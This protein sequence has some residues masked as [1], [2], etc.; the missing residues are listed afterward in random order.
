MNIYKK[1]ILCGYLFGLSVT[2]LY[3]QLQS[4]NLRTEY[5]T[6]PFVDASAPR[7]SWELDGSGFNRFQTAYQ[8]QV[9][10][11]LSKFERNQADLWD[12]DKV[13]SSQTN[14]IVYKGKKLLSGQEV[15]WRVRTWDEQGKVGPWSTAA[16]WEM[17]KLNN[18]DWQAQWIGYD[19]NPLAKQNTTYH[20]PPSPYL[21]TERKIEKA[22]QSARL[23]IASLGLHEF[24]VNGQKIGDDYFASGWTD[25]HKRVHYN[26]YDITQ[27]ISKGTNVFGSI[28]GPGW[29]A[30][31]LGYALLVGTKQVTQFYGKFPLLKAQIEITY[32]DGSSDTISTD[33]SWKAQIGAIQEADFLQG[34]LHDAN[35]ELIGWDLA[36]YDDK[37]WKEVQII[38]K[39]T[40]AVLSLYPSNPVRV[41]EK[42]YPKSITPSKA[43]TYMV[44]FG[45]NFAGNIQVHVKG[46]KGDTLTFRYGEM[47]YPDGRLMTE[48]LRSARATDYYVLRGDPN[49]ETW[50]PKFTFHGFQ[51]VE[52]SGLKF[53]PKKDFIEGLVLSSNLQNVG[54]FQ[55]DNAMLNQ[56]YSNI[57]WTQRANYL[58][59][60]TDCPQRDERLGW[61]G[62]AQVYMRSAAFIADIAPFHT[63]WIQDLHDSQWPNGAYP[64]YAP[65]PVNAKGDAAI[66]SSDTFSPGWSEA[67]IIC[68]Y[69]IYRTYNDTR[70]VELSMPYM[71]RFMDFLQSRTQQGIFK[72]GSFEDISPKGGF[73]DWLSVGKK[74]SPDLL[75]SMY[76]YYCAKLM[77]EMSQAIDRDDLQVKYTADMHSIKD[78]FKKHFMSK[79]KKLKADAEHYGNGDGYVDGQLGFTGHTQTSYA[80]ALYFG[81]L[82]EEDAVAAGNYLRQLIIDNDNKLTTGFL[83]FKPL[84]PTLSQSGSS[85]KA[86]ALLLSTEYPSL[87]YEVINGATSIWERWDSYIQGE[88]FRHNAAMNSFSH[89]AFGAVNEWMFENMIGIKALSPGYNTIIIRPEIEP[90]TIGAVDGSYHS[91][92]GL[93][94]SSWKLN[95]Q[96]VTQNFS[97]PIN[98]NATICIPDGATDI[99]LNNDSLERH[100]LVKKQEVVGN[101]SRLIVGSGNYSLTYT[102]K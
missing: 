82:D 88:G 3:A 84:L 83:G 72:E 39:P 44:D 95:N 25:Y 8:I 65:M 48:N 102:K 42:L 4:T 43:N 34:E 64:V 49:G 12:T 63:K 5:K 9:S 30:G 22:V 85:D 21:R 58:D 73:A 13:L 77:A 74:T 29:Y 81:I 66:R 90:N 18:V 57:V 2:F 87:G 78:A 51:Y 11:D 61:T 76:Y 60:P 35:K 93:I 68:T 19:T 79:D 56:L 46:A 28:L 62:D 86:Y 1:I 98:V 80:N 69:E 26:V 52:V 38:E 17:G 67:G 31:Y 45:Q 41:I 101:E 14:Q 47:C 37:G 59:V 10:S 40:N 54:K 71:I 24:Y 50:T 20:L 94:K 33:K 91:I 27:H 100:S 55:S 32:K 96:R 36:S 6:N 92:S 99:K 89:Y 16:K 97:I 53:D 7:L 23:Y 70:I 75:A 15:W